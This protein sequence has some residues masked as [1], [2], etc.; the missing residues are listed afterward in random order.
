MLFGPLVTQFLWNEVIRPVCYLEEYGRW[1]CLAQDISLAQQK[2]L[3]DNTA[4]YFC[5]L[6]AADIQSFAAKN[7]AVMDILFFECDFWYTHL[8]ACANPKSQI[9]AERLSSHF[10][11]EHI[12]KLLLW[13]W[14]G[15][16]EIYGNL[17]NY[18]WVTYFPY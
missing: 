17:T 7:F 10:K 14:L 6:S 1:K 18:S 9:S 5:L 8:Y 2:S 3:K 15:F 13:Q 11:V 16:D 12:D 4:L